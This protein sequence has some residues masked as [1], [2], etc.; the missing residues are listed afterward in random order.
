MMGFKGMSSG[1][2][3]T[4]GKETSSGEVSLEIHHI[5]VGQGDATLLLVRGADGGLTRSIL[6]DAGRTGLQVIAYFEELKKRT[7]GFRKLDMVITSH[8]D[9]DHIGGFA[10]L[11]GDEKYVQDDVI[12]YDLGRPANA[13]TDYQNYE[14]LVW[15]QEHRQRI[16]FGPILELSGITLTCLA[17]N[18]AMAG[19]NAK[20]V[21]SFDAG[22]EVAPS[23]HIPP[24]DK[25]ATSVA[26]LLEFGSFR[27]FTAGD[28]CGFYE[29]GVVHFLHPYFLKDSSHVCAWKLGH[30]GANEASSQD[31]LRL[32]VPRLGVISCGADNVFGHPAPGT[33]LRL[34]ELSKH[35]V[36]N[37]MATAKI[38][39]ET[40]MGFPIGQIPSG[41]HGSDGHGPIVISV[42]ETQANAHMFS[43]RSKKSAEQVLQCGTRQPLSSSVKLEEHRVSGKRKQTEEG[44]RAAKMRQ[45]DRLKDILATLRSALATKLGDAPQVDLA[46]LDVGAQLIRIAKR[47]YNQAAIDAREE[48][49]SN[50]FAKSAL[51][52][53]MDKA[54]VLK[55]LKK[56]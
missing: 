56:L 46:D 24:L 55:T 41:G 43:V 19:S 37:Y 25:N 10:L 33:L 35:E 11:F 7:G 30:H 54:D 48:W 38:V 40:G 26:L 32:M 20:R 27:Y 45:E 31:V 34:E 6:I 42:T 15:L 14:N 21:W 18:A 50:A 53:M 39:P 23:Q 13:D 3:S 1:H 9:S 8:Y 44:E 22:G 12:F 16:P 51:H 29:E 17:R 4:K 47:I 52:G 2:P 28:L 5:D 36:C 49:A